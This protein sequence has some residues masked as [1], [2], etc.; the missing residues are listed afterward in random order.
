MRSFSAKQ[1]KSDGGSRK[2]RRDDTEPPSADEEPESKQK[3]GV[4]ALL[5]SG[6]RI[7]MMR[8]VIG[9]T[10]EGASVGVEMM[11]VW[12]VLMVMQQVIGVALVAVW[13][14]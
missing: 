14:A 10:E 7:L 1:K 11:N 12:I 4:S 9:V 3:L 8:F 5:A 6:G 2:R 13:R